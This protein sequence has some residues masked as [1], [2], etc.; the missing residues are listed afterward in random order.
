MRQ[1]EI[2]YS[3]PGFKQKLLHFAAK[4]TYCVFLDSCSTEIDQYG[5]FDFLVGFSL[6]ESP[7]TYSNLESLEDAISHDPFA[8]RFGIFGYELKNSLYPRLKDEFVAA[9]FPEMLFFQADV[10]VAKRK[11]SKWLNFERGYTPE[12]FAEIK[13]T[14]VQPAKVAAFD[15]FS[16]NFSQE[17]YEDTVEKLRQHIKEGDSYEINL[18]Q[19]FKGKAKVENPVAL[20]EKLIQKSPT[21]FAGY[22]KWEGKHLLCASPERFLQLRSG[23][24]CTQPIKG[25]IRRGKNEAEDAENAATLQN[26]E[27][28]RAE[29]V[30]IV[31]LSRNDL[32]KSCEINAVEVPHLF[33]VQQ[34][35]Q[36]LHL[37][38]TIT[39]EKRKDLHPITAIKH[40][41][42]PGSMTGA[43]KVRSCELI[44]QYE[45]TPRG[46]YAGSLGYFAPGGDFDLNVVIR[47]L[48]YDE[49]TETLSYHVGGAITWDSEARAEYEETLLKA[50]GIVEVMG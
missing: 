18:S 46:M 7:K 39:G 36:V 38:S 6:S 11:G 35:P 29:N 32:Y 12:L 10:V 44:S 8:W 2:L 26:S 34:F 13:K 16:S 21:P 4:Q 48:I 45:Q 5:Q 3:G 30:M 27:K 14:V 40:A 1:V 15:N 17:Q 33:E 23:R 47:S 49:A 50:K 25:T 42:P 20:W 24:L 22:G 31:D 28:E 37:V 19:N 41:F 9:D 43:P